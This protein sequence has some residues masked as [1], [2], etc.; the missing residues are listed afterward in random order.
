MLLMITIRGS[1]VREQNHDLVDR[2]W[3]LGEIVLRASETLFF[4]IE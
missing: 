4:N 1:T 3:V 2:L